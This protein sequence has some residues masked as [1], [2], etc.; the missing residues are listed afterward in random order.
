MSMRVDATD[1]VGRGPLSTAALAVY[2]ALVLEVLLLLTLAPTILAAAFLVPHPSNVW[3]YALAAVPA[4]PALSAGLYACRAWSVERDQ[5]PAAPFWRGYVR[6]FLPVLRWWVPALLVG[7][8]L[9]LDIAFG[10]HVPGGAAL[11][12]AAVALLVLLTVVAGH[13]L[14]VTTF[15]SFRLAD[16]VRVA[17]YCVGR[18]PLAS[19]GVVA[20]VVA[21]VGLAMLGGDMLV[22]LLAFAFLRLGYVNARSVLTLVTETFTRHD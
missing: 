20:L 22:L 19:L 15:F 18:C 12:P 11:R 7:S 2:R 5:R 10:E 9:V 13:L 1:E 8:I 16:A 17:V 4:G 21:A 14:V 6:G 3:L